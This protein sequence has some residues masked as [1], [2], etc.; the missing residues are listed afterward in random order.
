ML[1]TKKQRNKERNRA[2]T[3]PH[4]PTGGGV[5]KQA[6]VEYI[7]SPWEKEGKNAK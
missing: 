7:H 3:I 2:K 6:S 5:K 1:L 4:P